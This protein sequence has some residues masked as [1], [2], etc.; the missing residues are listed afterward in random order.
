MATLTTNI[1]H[2]GKRVDTFASIERARSAVQSMAVGFGYDAPTG[3]TRGKF[4]RRGRLVG[5]WEITE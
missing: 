1:S 2:Y 4:E 5:T 3:S